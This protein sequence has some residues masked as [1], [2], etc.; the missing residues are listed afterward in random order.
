MTF[1]KR[2]SCVDS[3][4]LSFLSAIFYTYRFPSQQK[5]NQI[6]HMNFYITTAAALS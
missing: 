5:Y 1:I 3:F 4:V 2:L 6:L